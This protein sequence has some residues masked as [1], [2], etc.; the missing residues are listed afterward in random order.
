MCVCFRDVAVRESAVFERVGGLNFTDAEEQEEDVLICSSDG[1]GQMKESRRNRSPERSPSTPGAIDP[2][3]FPCERCSLIMLSSHSSVNPR[4]AGPSAIQS[5]ILS[6]IRA[7]PRARACAC[8]RAR[9]CVCVRR[10]NGFI[11]ACARVRACVCK[12]ETEG[13]L[14]RVGLFSL[15]AVAAQTV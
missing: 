12:R 10:R 15:L 13:G 6:A 2:E 8:A 1:D 7:G 5:F 4:A 11:S 9:V 3:L 14:Y